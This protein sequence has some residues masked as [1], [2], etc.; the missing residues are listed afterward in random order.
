MNSVSRAEP[1]ASGTKPIFK[2]NDYCRVKHALAQPGLVLFVANFVEYLNHSDRYVKNIRLVN[3]QKL[4]QLFPH[5]TLDPTL[6][7]I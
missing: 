4:R 2:L 7:I 1:Y 6:L 3:K 5:I